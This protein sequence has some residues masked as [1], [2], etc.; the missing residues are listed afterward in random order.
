LLIFE[1]KNCNQLGCSAEVYY[2]YIPG[3]DSINFTLD[4]CNLTFDFS[5]IDQ[6]GYKINKLKYVEDVCPIIWEGVC[7]DE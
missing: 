6:I 3:S 2:T 7:L 1:D 5:K 4:V